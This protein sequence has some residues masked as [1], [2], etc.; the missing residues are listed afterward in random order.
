MRRMR[1][2]VSCARCG[3]PDL[4]GWE[5]VDAYTMAITGNHFRRRCLSCGAKEMR[6]ARPDEAWVAA[7]P[8]RTKTS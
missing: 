6:A 2:W 1:R 4:T 7:K 5:P 8:E 3:A